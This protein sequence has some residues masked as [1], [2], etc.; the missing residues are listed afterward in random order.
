MRHDQ[1]MLAAWL[2]CVEFNDQHQL[3]SS[4]GY[5]PNDDTP[6]KAYVTTSDAYV[7]PTGQCVI[8]LGGLAYPV[9]LD[10]LD[11]KAVANAG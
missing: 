1:A 9:P 11:P 4:F 3:G 8:Q 7:L 6:T 5:R 2:R 10:R